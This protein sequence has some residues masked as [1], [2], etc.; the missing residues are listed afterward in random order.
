MNDFEKLIAALPAHR[1][2]VD[3]DG[4]QGARI[5]M[6]GA[7]LWGANLRTKEEALASGF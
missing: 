6:V 5:E 4:A 3:T 7:N 1:L 2:Y